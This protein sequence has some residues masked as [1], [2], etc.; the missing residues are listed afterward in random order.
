MAKERKDCIVI[1]YKDG[2]TVKAKYHGAVGSTDDTD[3]KKDVVAEFALGANQS[4]A[5]DLMSAA[6][7]AMN[8]DESIS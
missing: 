2:G 4:K 8:S 1:L 6:E 5:D 3:M 7:A